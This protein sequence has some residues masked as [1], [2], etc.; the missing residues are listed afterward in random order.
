MPLEPLEQ[1]YKS[2]NWN[3]VEI[4]GHDFYQI[5]AA[6]KEAAECS[7]KP[8]VIIANTVPGKGVSFMEGRCEWHGKAPSEKEA[9]AA[10]KELA[11]E[12][13]RLEAA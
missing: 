8:T 6:C 12:A 9:A 10:L 4:D 2:F 7:S 5:L 3:A 13:A 11:A 1:K